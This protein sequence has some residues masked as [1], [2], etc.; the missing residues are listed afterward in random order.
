MQARN[1]TKS[2]LGESDLEIFELKSGRKIEI[3]HPTK[4]QTENHSNSSWRTASDGVNGA[5]ED[6]RSSTAQAT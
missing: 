1:E 2:S 3:W 6:P 4:K 5:L